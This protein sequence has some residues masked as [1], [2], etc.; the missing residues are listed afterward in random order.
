L[1]LLATVALYGV[2]PWCFLRCQ[3]PAL[4]PTLRDLV[5]QSRACADLL[6][7]YVAFGG[8]RYPTFYTN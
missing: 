2:L 3:L 6:Q 4:V 5:S 1:A 7:P 8:N